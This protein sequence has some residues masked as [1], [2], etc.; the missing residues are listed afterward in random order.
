MSSK[1]VILF[2]SHLTF[3]VYLM[4]LSIDHYIAACLL[5]VCETEVC[6]SSYLDVATPEN[7]KSAF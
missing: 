6:I 1:I 7:I 3:I 4:M 5:S 2:L